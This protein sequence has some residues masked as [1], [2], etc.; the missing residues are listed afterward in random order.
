MSP[1][2]Y[3]RLKEEVDQFYKDNNLTGPITYLQTQKLPFLQAVVKEAMRVLPSIVFQL[4]RYSP[5]GFS[6]RGQEIP[7][8]TAVGISPVAQNHDT[9]IWGPDADEFRPERWLEDEARAKY[10]DTSLMTFGGNG[11][12]MCIGRNIALVS[13]D[14]SAIAF[15]AN[16]HF[17]NSQLRPLN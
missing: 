3:N 4:L 9:E 11:P 2:V 10:W 1:H 8:G 7:P 6:V 5:P 13:R 15:A 12:R 17:P 16:L 14:Y